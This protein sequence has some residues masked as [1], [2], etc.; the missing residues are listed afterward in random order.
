MYNGH[1]NTPLTIMII[2][3]LSDAEL[4]SKIALY[5]KILES[6]TREQENRSVEAARQVTVTKLA[7]GHFTF[8][9]PTAGEFEAKRIAHGGRYRVWRRVQGSRGMKRGPVI[10][11]E[12]YLGIQAIR[13]HIARDFA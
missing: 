4:Q 6:L 11:Q 3:N 2:Q 9:H 1:I 5:G 10:I 12:S 8:Q 13:Q 7:E